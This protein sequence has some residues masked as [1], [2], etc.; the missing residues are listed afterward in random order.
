MSL[1]SNWFG[2][3]KGIDYWEEPGYESKSIGNIDQPLKLS[4]LN[5]FFLANTV[6]EI[7]NP[8]DFYADRGS[9]L[10][11]FI[12]DKDNN[13]IEN[14]E[15]KRLIADINPLFSFND[16]MYQYI[17]SYMSDG[18]AITLIT[19]PSTYRKP[20]ANSITR[21]DVLQPDFLQIAEHRNISPLNITSY[22]ELIKS[23]KYNEMTQH[24]V[25]LEIPKLRFDHIDQ[26]R[27]Q[28]SLVLCKSPLFKAVRPVNN[29]L[30]T[31]SARHNVYVNNGAAG[32][33][34]KKQGNQNTINEAVDPTT[35]QKILDD[36]NERNG[37]TGRR[38]FW[39]ISSV[40]LEFI[41]TLAHIKDLMPFEETL[42]DSIA[43][44]SVYQ[45]PRELVMGA[46]STTFNNKAEA[47]RSVWENGLMSMVETARYNLTR[48]LYLDKVGLQIGVD[49]SSVSALSQN[50]TENQTLIA[51]KLTNLQTLKT[52]QPDNKEID[53]QIDLI[54]QG[55]G[56]N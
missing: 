19:V 37:I 20:S 31:Y 42:N 5:A 38:N 45:L 41:N 8:I 40:P 53:K 9:K 55:Y 35:R 27:R 48:A 13:E 32:Y 43:I 17:F 30:A 50:E 34:V 15:Y 26:T 36:I 25:V 29:L 14:S 24:Y 52:L 2:K 22:N 46:E 44:S 39:G 54:I 6:T 4:D 16:L 23:A 28:D 11:Y 33:L 12:A 21:L 51:Q 18:N 10:R 3:Q 49:Y 7:Y 1:L 56:K 47:E